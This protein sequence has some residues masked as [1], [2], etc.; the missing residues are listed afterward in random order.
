MPLERLQNGRYLSLR[1]LG[2]GSMGEVYLFD[3]TVIKR[4][5]AVKMTLAD[6]PGYPGTDAVKDAVKLF[7]REA[8]AIASLE[9]PSI[10]PIY[11]F[12]EEKQDDQIFTYMV[13]PYC[14]EGTLMNWLEQHYPA[15]PVPPAEVAYFIEQ[16]ASAL[17]YAHEHGV[18]HQDVKPPNFLLRLHAR[19]QKLPD[20][21]LADF[22]IARLGTGTTVNTMNVGPRGTP[23]YMSP[24][25]WQANPLPASDQYALAVLAYQLLTHSFPF[26]GE[27]IHQLMYQ[28]CF[29]QPDPPSKRQPGLPSTLDAVILRGLAK[30]PEERF[31]DVLAF[32]RALREALQPSKPLRETVSS[33]NEEQTDLA[34][35]ITAPTFPLPDQQPV[36]PPARGAVP[37]SFSAPTVAGQSMPAQRSDYVAPVTSSAQG[38]R[39]TPQ[40]FI[41]PGPST[42]PVRTQP[43]TPQHDSP[44]Y[45]TA[46]QSRL[47][48]QPVQYTPPPATTPSP[49]PAQ[50]RKRRAGRT[51]ALL[52]SLV[53]LVVIGGTGVAAWYYLFALPGNTIK[54]HT[55]VTPTPTP[56]PNVNTYAPAMS[57][58]R[59][60]DP[61][62]QANYWQA[63]PNDGAT[64]GYCLFQQNAYVASS[65]VAQTYTLC[66]IASN[67]PVVGDMTF[68]V[69]MQILH[70][71]CGGFTFRG[72]YQST[73]GNFYYFDVCSD[74]K[75][76]LASYTS[77]GMIQELQMSNSNVPFAALKANPQLPL[78][79]A[80]VAQGSSLTFYLNHQLIDK[81]NDTTYTS[82]QVSLLCYEVGNPTEVAFSNARLW[83]A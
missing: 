2:R 71:D 35:T 10:L 3:D 6:P 29:T 82:G 47:Q 19:E 37:H 39:S 80:V 27:Q 60:Y 64:H 40:P 42:P 4:K 1:L 66:P 55:V 33:R 49:A 32:A 38:D 50:P 43:N 18:I 31:P 14:Q 22:G 57:T 75:H 8:Q 65:N 83:T 24:E 77:F 20:L 34:F 28:H 11:D 48:L 46:A 62:Q 53:L 68:E 61:L 21:L 59:Y 79:L 67:Q 81:M 45:Y 17:Q 52:L 41:L 25:Q 54:P 74:G 30:K 70:G 26:Q 16:A 63:N 73:V 36:P 72:N 7:K 51:I 69:Q 9:H 23:R 76:Y 13:M 5:V 58:L 44:T 12:G 78:T 56:N 15:G